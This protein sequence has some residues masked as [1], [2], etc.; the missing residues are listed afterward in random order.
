ML[1][2]KASVLLH[3]DKYPPEDRPAAEERF[4]AL[5][6]GELLRWM[7]RGEGGK[8]QWGIE[9]KHMKLCPTSKSDTSMT[10]RWISMI[11][12]QRLMK[13]SEKTFSKSIDRCFYETQSEPG[14][15]VE[16]RCD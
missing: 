1:D 2:R 11:R 9:T 5:Q 14:V 3:P 13:V 16:Q 15:L 10:P 7:K 12:S 8:T 6:V 4:K